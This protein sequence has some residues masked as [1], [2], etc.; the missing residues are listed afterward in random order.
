LHPS[1]AIWSTAYGVSAGQQ[2]G[3]LQLATTGRVRAA[4][5]NGS[6]A[7]I[8]LTPPSMLEGNGYDVH[9]GSQV[10]TVKDASG[11]YASLWRGSAASWVNLNP[12]GAT[13]CEAFGVYDDKQVGTVSDGSFPQA[14]MWSGSGASYVNLHALLPPDLNAGSSAA[15]DVWTDG[16]TIIVTGTASVGS[17]FSDQAV[18]W[19][20]T[21]DIAVCDDIDFNNNNVFPEDQ[22]VIDFF[23]V[24]SGADCPTCND[25]DFNNNGVFPEDQDV[26][27]FFNVLA[28]GECP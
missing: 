9:N 18:M 21:P 25:I 23:N 17:T 20:F 28:G 5:W 13:F 6:S 3:T 1:N 26:I 10:G 16:S 11:N 15:Q 19:M 14:A 27:D 2:V 24:L 22:D 8:D 7:W 12:P 4:L